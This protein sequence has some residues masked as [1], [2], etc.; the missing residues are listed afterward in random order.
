[1]NDLSLT[2]FLKIFAKFDVNNCNV[3][4]F[5][6]FLCFLVIRLKF[7]WKSSGWIDKLRT[8]IQKSV[9]D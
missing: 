9:E 8:N 3:K 5:H 6:F 2:K 4:R 1:M 7:N